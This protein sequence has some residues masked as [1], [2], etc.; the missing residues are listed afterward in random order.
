MWAFNQPSTCALFNN[1]IQ[2]GR[3]TGVKAE[4]GLILIVV[5][6]TKG[7][8]GEISVLYK[9]VHS[10]LCILRSIWLYI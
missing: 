1:F 4:H 3:L 10:I 8:N 6:L 7:M 2:I 5:L 9:D